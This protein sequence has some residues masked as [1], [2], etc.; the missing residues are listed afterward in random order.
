MKKQVPRK[1]QN[2]SHHFFG[3]YPE[4]TCTV[5]FY[6]LFANCLH[7]LSFFLVCDNFTDFSGNVMYLHY[8]GL[9]V[10]YISLVLTL[11][12]LGFY[13]SWNTYV[14]LSED[15]IYSMVY[16]FTHSHSSNSSCLHVTKQ[17]IKQMW[18][19][20]SWSVHFGRVREPDKKEDNDE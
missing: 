18:F 16:S 6:Y 19:L 17:W 1:I 13:K 4:N 12:F 14:I 20:F 3:F 10:R 8:W 7:W 5:C 11:I 9:E 2:K 15:F